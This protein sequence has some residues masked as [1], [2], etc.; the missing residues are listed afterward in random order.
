MCTVYKEV[1]VLTD[2]KEI[3]SKILEGR[4]LSREDGLRLYK[5]YNLAWLGYMADIVR[6]RISGDYVYYN[7]NRHVNLTNMCVARCKF[8]AFGRDETA[9]G[10][11]ALSKEEAL[12]M[13][14]KSAQ[15][16]DLRSLHIVSGLH[17]HWPFSYYFDLIK[18]IKTKF[19]K[20]HLKGFTG[21]EITHFA[22]ISG[23]TVREVLQELIAAGLE[24]MPGGGAEILSDRI[25][26]RL[27][28]N[29]ATAKEWLHV[30]REA[31]GLGLKTNA[32]MLYGHIETA[33]E[34]IDHLL[35]LR[36]LQDETGGFQ[37]F[38]CFPFHPDNTELAG[39]ITR[40]SYWDDL[41]TMAISRLMLDNFKNIKAY[42]VMLTLPVAQLA[43]GFGANDIDGTIKEERIMH[44]AGAKSSKALTPDKL[45]A[46]IKETGRTPV[47]CDCNFNIVKIL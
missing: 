9:A 8:C 25:R 17:P 42:W 40:T 31:H 30:A 24:A 47:E 2:M 7:V 23:K 1:N 22:K 34:R 36:E 32:S 26:G 19:P 3:E 39:E 43:L 37:T 21:V 13:I 45:V 27:C 35:A 16:P 15:D 5:C 4:R 29:K 18:E 6:Q 41:K 20:L 38:I 28:P 46:A 11:Y 33:E 12:R 44:A 10:A 14:E